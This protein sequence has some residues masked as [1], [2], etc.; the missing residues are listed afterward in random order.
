[1]NDGVSCETGTF[2]CKE[3]VS[4]SCAFIKDIVSPEEKESSRYG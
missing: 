3:L 1:M 4:Y 2:L